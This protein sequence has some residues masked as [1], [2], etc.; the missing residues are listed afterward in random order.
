MAVLASWRMGI[1][2]SMTTAWPICR[3][4]RVLPPKADVKRQSMNLR[5]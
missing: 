2:S 4:P 5:L 3:V 1:I